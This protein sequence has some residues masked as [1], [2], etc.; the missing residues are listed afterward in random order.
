MGF[1]AVAS[2]D[3]IYRRIKGWQMGEVGWGLAVYTRY[4]EGF[5]PRV[6][7]KLGPSGIDSFLFR[8]CR[9]AGGVFRGKCEVR[10]HNGREMDHL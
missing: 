7:Q 8:G 10:L 2:I 4:M 1:W 9:R 5:H 3:C 6:V